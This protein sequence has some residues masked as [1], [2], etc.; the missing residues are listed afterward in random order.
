MHA[1]RGN[2][3]LLPCAHL[4]HRS[5]P[6]APP[7]P[8]QILTYTQ[9]CGLVDR[10]RAL[11]GETGVGDAS[12]LLLVSGRSKQVALNQLS[13]HA[14]DLPPLELKELQRA[15]AVAF[16]K[17]VGSTGC[18]S[19]VINGGGKSHS[20]LRGVAVRQ[21]EGEAVMYARVPVRESTTT[22][23]LVDLLALARG[24]CRSTEALATCFIHLDIAHIIPASC[25]TMLFELLL[26]GCL[27]DTAT[28]R[29]FHRGGCE[30]RVE[31]PNSPN[32]KSAQALRFCSLLPTTVLTCDPEDMD[33]SAPAFSNH[34]LCTR[35][36]LPSYTEAIFVAKYLRAFRQNKF[37]PRKGD[38]YDGAWDPFGSEITSEEAF[39]F[40]SAACN[41]ADGPAPRPSFTAFRQFAMFMNTQLQNVSSYE[42]LDANTLAMLGGGWPFFKHA[43]LSLLIETGKDFSLRSVEQVACVGPP[44]PAKEARDPNL[45]PAAEGGVGG[46]GAAE[47]GP[48]ERLAEDDFD[49]DDMPPPAAAAPLLTRH[50]SSGH[51]EEVERVAA[52]APQGI[53]RQTTLELMARFGGMRSWESSDH[54]IVLFKMDPRTMGVAGV[55]LLSLNKQFVDGYIE[56]DL[57]YELEASGIDFSKDWAKITNDEGADML[58][59]IE[60]LFDRASGGRG[61]VGSM[62][63]GYVLT[64]DNLLK[65]ISIQLRMKYN[66]PVVR[67]VSLLSVSPRRSRR[68]DQLER[69]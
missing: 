6:V 65:M 5:S 7:I 12:T 48:V 47:G 4:G 10:L 57:K 32:N 44:P 63:D 54:P 1:S 8:P 39:S 52:A 46:G 42:L 14:V 55:D 19:S 17:H 28:C 62:D 21:A 60:G 43:F 23:S 22:A 68:G 41:Q 11:L 49:E 40:L 24:R 45:K 30:F 58:R 37:N 61:G 13:Q 33:L 36:V 64:V 29:I 53:T 66:L 9:Q 26:V 51:S 15:C 2:Q 38:A 20:I 18:V 59:G 69:P 34:P 31:V 3:P 35:V 50:S 56:R 67:G 16:E 27:R 25:N